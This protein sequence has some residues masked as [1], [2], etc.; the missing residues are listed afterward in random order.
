MLAIHLIHDG[1]R[2]HRGFQRRAYTASKVPTVEQS[3][4]F[5]HVWVKLRRARTRKA[6]TG[7]NAFYAVMEKSGVCETISG[8]TEPIRDQLLLW[9]SLA[10]QANNSGV[11]PSNR[12]RKTDNGCSPEQRPEVYSIPAGRDACGVQIGT[13]K[14]LGGATGRKRSKSK[15]NR[16]LLAEQIEQCAKVQGTRRRGG[17]EAS[18]SLAA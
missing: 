10:E 18:K 13:K 6:P 3:E 17:G 7:R 14:T 15:C 1:F 2:N 9:R 12:R 4:S 11:K 16:L 8:R 5:P